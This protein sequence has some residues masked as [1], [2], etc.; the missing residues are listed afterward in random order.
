MSLKP[1]PPRPMPPEMAWGTNHLTTD[2]PYKLIGDTLYS[3]YHD[4]NFADLYHKEGKPSISRCY[5]RS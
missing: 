4:E 3:S 5:C 1:Q 2:D